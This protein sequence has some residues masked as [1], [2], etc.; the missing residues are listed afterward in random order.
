VNSE[1]AIL[2]LYRTLKKYGSPKQNITDPGTQVKPDRGDTS[3][4]DLHC[5]ELGIEHITTSVRRPTVRDKNEA[6][7][8]DY[9]T[10]AQLF[11]EHWSFIR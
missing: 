1:N 4:F 11:C 2:L 8:K 3:M 10:E 5:R 6:F 7:H 9:Q